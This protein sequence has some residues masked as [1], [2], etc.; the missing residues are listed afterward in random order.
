VLTG[1]LETESNDPELTRSQTET[2]AAPVACDHQAPEDGSEEEK[3][4]YQKGVNSSRPP[5]KKKF[6]RRMPREKE[7]CGERENWETARRD[8]WLRELLTDSSEGESEDGYTRF[9][10]SSRWIA[11]MTGGAAEASLAET[12]DAS[13]ENFVRG[14]SATLA[15]LTGRSG[16]GEPA[17]LREAL[18]RRQ[19]T[20]CAKPREGQRRC[21]V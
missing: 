5:T 7:V 14:A 15:T 10:E 13:S 4:S 16:G 12:R 9:E 19:R 17:A 8:A 6:K 2:A 20:F 1:G 11:K 21:K 18:E 3:R